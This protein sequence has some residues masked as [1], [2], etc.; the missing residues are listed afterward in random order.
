MTRTTLHLAAVM[1]I[2]L[3]AAIAAAQ[4]PAAPAV[5]SDQAMQ[6]GP[7]G[8]LAI[9][10]IQGTKGGPAV[11]GEEVEVIVFHR[12]MPVKQIKGNLDDHGVLL[13][14]DLPVGIGIRPLVRIKHAGVL[15]QDAAALM[16][17]EKPGANLDITVYEVT[18][19]MPAWKVVMRHLVAE[20]AEGGMAVSETLVVENTS[21]QTWLGAPPDAANRRATV[22]LDLPAGA[23]D[24]QLVQGFHGWCCSAYAG[25]KLSIQMP[26]MPGKMT[27]KFAYFVPA[28]DG[29]I[30]LRVA[31]PAPVGH[32][33]FF[34]PDSGLKAEPT[35]VK[36]GGSEQMGAER[37]TMFQSDGIAAGESV[38]VVLTS[39]ASV[40]VQAAAGG[41]MSPIIWIGAGLLGVGVVAGLAMRIGK[42]KGAA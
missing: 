36:E 12:E 32:A 15:Y 27:Y 37:V 33:A 41:G 11:G 18:E 31:A 10:A 16:D 22:T 38:G 28:R 19:T 24:I 2:G 34:V 23:T 1:G 35:L 5:D 30:D 9:R 8:M 20:K 3:C 7:K 25:T 39:L 29:V 40:P 14:G 26:F 6:Q 4:S 42:R 21:D 17:A 13:V